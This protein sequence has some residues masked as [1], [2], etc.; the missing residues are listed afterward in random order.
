MKIHAKWEPSVLCTQN[1]DG[2]SAEHSP[3]SFKP[4]WK[5]SIVIRSKSQIKIFSGPVAVQCFKFDQ[6]FEFSTKIEH[7]L[8][9]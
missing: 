7:Y 2:A 3:L 9:H 8:L 4:C 6:I 5:I 1:K